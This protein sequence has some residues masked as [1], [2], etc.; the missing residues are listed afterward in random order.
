LLL[1]QDVSLVRQR[2]TQVTVAFDD[3][4]VADFFDDQ[5]DQGKS[6]SEFARIW[7]HTHPG[8]SPEPSST[9]EATFQRCFGNA[10]WALML[11]LAQGGKTYARLRVGQEPCVSIR[12]PVELDFSLSFPATAHQLW[13]AEFASCVQV[14]M[15][16]GIETWTTELNPTDVRG[17]P[18]YDDLDGWGWDRLP[19]PHIGFSEDG[20]VVHG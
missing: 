5:V 18:S 17:L 15:P 2:C 20:E 6:P 16:M 11:I 3:Q 4:A 14:D 10:D 13:T 19:E 12:L 7:V 8:S 1:I 9:D